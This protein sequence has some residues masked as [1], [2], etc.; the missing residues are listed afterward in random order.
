MK[1][2]NFSIFLLLSLFVCLLGHGYAY[3]DDENNFTPQQRGQFVEAPD[4]FEKKIFKIDNTAVFWKDN[5]TLIFSIPNKDP[6]VDSS[7]AGLPKVVTLNVNTG[8]IQST[9]Y[10]GNLVCYSDTQMVV[11]YP[12]YG[13]R[14]GV[15]TYVGKFGQ[16]LEKIDQKGMSSLNYDACTTV[17]GGVVQ[18]KYFDETSVSSGDFDPTSM[19]NIQLK[20]LNGENIASLQ[21]PAMLGPSGGIFML[22]I[23]YL[24]KYFFRHA[25]MNI[26][27]N[28]QKVSA[29]WLLKDGTIEL[30]PTQPFLASLAQVRPGSTL[31][32]GAMP[33]PTRVGYFWDFTPTLPNWRKQGLY[34]EHD[35]TLYRVDDASVHSYPPS[36]NGCR[37][38]Y[39]RV[40]GSMW[41][42][43][44]Y[45]P[46]S[47]RRQLIVIDVCNGK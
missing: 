26:S 4:M 36:P 30:V 39:S 20:K 8:E 15:S 34:Y 9:P 23:P 46:G 33:T 42:V 32:G 41:P 47:D 6:A 17:S 7:L 3:A 22:Y 38:V 44:P 24:G 2:I 31:P 19:R 40:L 11:Y 43:R 12:P 25:P 45:G 35:G 29:F 5:E 27:W 28:G 16:A 14:H 18:L 10:T 21:V 1:A 13:E 37:I